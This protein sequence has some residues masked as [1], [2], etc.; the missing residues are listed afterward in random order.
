MKGKTILM[1]MALALWSCSG[2][3]SPQ[4][5][6]PRTAFIYPDYTEVT[7]PQT[8]APLNFVCEEAGCTKVQAVFKG[9][10]ESFSVSG[11]YI[12][13]PSKKW[14]KLLGENGGGS[15]EVTVSAKISGVW[16]EFSPFK[17]YVSTDAVD[18][19]VAYRKIAPGYEY[20][21]RMGIYEREL[22]SFNEKAIIENTLSPGMCV[23]CHSFNKTSPEKMSLHIRG[24]HGTTIMSTPSA[25]EFLDTA[26]DSTE[27]N[28]VYPYWH[29]SGDYIAYS[30]NTTRQGF[31]TADD[32][33]VEVFD[34][35]SAIIVSQPSTR[36]V[37]ISNLLNRT[38][39]LE[40]L[41]AFSP[42]GRT[43]YFSRAEN[44]P[45][46]QEYDSLRYNICS[47]AFDPETGRFGDEIRTVFDAASLGESAT[48]ARP[49]YDGRHILFTLAD[50]GYFTIWHK[51]AELWMLDLE[52]GEARP[53]SELNSD[54]TESFHN[55]S[56][57]SRWV[58]FTSRRDDGLYTRLYIAHIDAEGNCS[59]PFLLPQE[60]PEE[61]YASSLYSYNVPDFVNAPVK[62]DTRKARKGIES[63]HRT[64][65]T[66]EK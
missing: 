40:T 1:A 29:P 7:V 44:K 45:L 31:H 38:E 6:V 13:I 47:I 9:N 20:F 28:F 41:P 50:Y 8:I 65:C 54:D 10:N 5:V 14:H 43:L 19:G 25:M 42:D 46:P 24:A 66:A 33:R 64:K 59:K 12:R 55:W 63:Q 60:N 34:F 32:R 58:V 3:I 62:M 37:L 11:D 27:G 39:S 61:Y 2:N 21:S 35:Q 36:K 15:I 48:C 22:S 17:I 30:T 26:T 23:N 4:E 52:S 53:A 18:Y 49:S 51:E 16:K 56:S 57:N